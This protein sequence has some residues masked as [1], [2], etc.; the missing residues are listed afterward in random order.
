M[1]PG[2]QIPMKVLVECEALTIHTLA[3]RVCGAGIVLCH[4]PKIPPIAF[5]CKMIYNY[6]ALAYGEGDIDSDS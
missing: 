1:T 2:R 6:S 5:L 3:A 4:R